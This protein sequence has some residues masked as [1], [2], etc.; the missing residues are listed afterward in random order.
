M[1]GG[2]A[3]LGAACCQCEGCAIQPQ[4][5]LLSTWPVKLCANFQ[6]KRV[7]KYNKFSAG[8][9]KLSLRLL[10]K[11]YASHL[12]PISHSTALGPDFVDIPICEHGII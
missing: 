2:W 7:T 8:F 11:H 12:K 1:Q 4:I 3:G 10:E 6:L 5:G 9:N